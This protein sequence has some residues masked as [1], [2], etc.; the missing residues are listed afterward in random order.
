MPITFKWRR[1]KLLAKKIQFSKAD[2]VEKAG[3]DQ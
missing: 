1:N 3:I 2:S